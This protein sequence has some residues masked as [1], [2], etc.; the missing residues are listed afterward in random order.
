MNNW[1]TKSLFLPPKLAYHVKIALFSILISLAVPVLRG[2]QV[3]SEDSLFMISMMFFQMEVFLFIG[4][5]LFKFQQVGTAKEIT[6]SIVIRFILFYLLCIVSA[7]IVF[8]ANNA[9][10]YAIHN[11]PLN[12]LFPTF[13]EFQFNGWFLSTN[14]GLLIGAF[15][16]FIMLWQE[17]LKREQNLKEENLIF[18]YETLKNQVNPHFL[19]NSLNTLAS[20]ISSNPDLAEKYVRSLSSIYRYITDNS[21]KESIPLEME[22]EF[23]QNFFYLHKMRDENKIEL[24]IAGVTAEGFQII[25]VSLQILIENA[26]K[27]NIA[28]K[29]NP[30]LV[31][32]FQE[33]A[34]I[35]V[36]NNVQ[37]TNT[38]SS[39]LKQGLKNL[40]SRILLSTGKE[41]EIQ[42]TST[43]FT[44]K[45]P[46]KS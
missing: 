33:E 22:L 32:V 16:F 18:K 10:R 11:T 36:R 45:V 17:S 7:A 25:P 14:S 2:Q 35:V 24:K 8:F 41:I 27:H 29:D 31:E 6:W 40:N 12:E 28:T 23:I 9:I 42:E 5:S 37:K 30:L 20:F 43:F 15:I 4:K 19:F 21:S 44:V 38:L 13:F 46:L 34:Y 3:F 39:S 26:L 1:I